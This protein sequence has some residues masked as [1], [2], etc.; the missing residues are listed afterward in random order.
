MVKRTQKLITGKYW[1]VSSFFRYSLAFAT[2]VDLI[3]FCNDVGV[4][5]SSFAEAI[6]CALAQPLLNG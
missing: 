2:F 3:A 6:P 4:R 1:D 5:V